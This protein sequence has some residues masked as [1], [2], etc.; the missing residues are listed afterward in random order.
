LDSAESGRIRPDY[1]G[2]CNILDIARAETKTALRISHYVDT[3]QVLLVF[4]DL[5]WP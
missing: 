4:E 3:P 2:E 1:V 5:S